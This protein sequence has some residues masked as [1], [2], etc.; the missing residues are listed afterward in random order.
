MSGKLTWGHLR[1]LSNL[2][3]NSMNYYDEK[4]RTV[5]SESNNKVKDITKTD[6]KYKNI[7]M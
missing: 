5:D 1:L 3:I 6:M 7:I 2:E 4:K